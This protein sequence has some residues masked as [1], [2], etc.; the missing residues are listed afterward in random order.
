MHCN[1]YLNCSSVP[2]LTPHS[3]G[4]FTSPTQLTD[5]VIVVIHTLLHFFLYLIFTYVCIYIYIYVC[6]CIHVAHCISGWQVDKLFIYCNLL[7]K[8]F[9]LVQLKIGGLPCLTR[10]I[11]QCGRHTVS[12]D[13]FTAEILVNVEMLSSTHYNKTFE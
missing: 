11:R 10:A 1:F 3:K 2:C 6:L 4:I 5:T 13:C 8:H 9:H 7:H 12:I